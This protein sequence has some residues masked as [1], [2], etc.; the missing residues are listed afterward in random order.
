MRDS[1][2]AEGVGSHGSPK[3]SPDPLWFCSWQG[4]WLYHNFI[5]IPL[6]IIFFAGVSKNLGIPAFFREERNFDNFF[7]HTRIVIQ[8]H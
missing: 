8:K 7:A 3:G 4:L 6:I 1:W 5:V 2:V